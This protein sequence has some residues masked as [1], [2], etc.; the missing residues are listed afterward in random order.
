M[1]DARWWVQ[2]VMTHAQLK[3]GNFILEVYFAILHSTWFTFTSNLLS[4][5]LWAG[6]KEHQK[7]SFFAWIIVLDKKSFYSDVGVLTA[8]IY[9]TLIRVWNMHWYV[10]CVFL[11]KRQLSCDISLIQS[12]INIFPS[13]TLVVVVRGWFL[14]FKALQTPLG[15]SHMW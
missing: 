9:Y 5:H 2:C 4:I 1:K 14:S 3:Q 15:A 11:L 7:I 8:D 13:N 10:Q 12:G 6:S